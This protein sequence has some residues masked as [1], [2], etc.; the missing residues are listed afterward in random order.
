MCV[1]ARETGDV[2]ICSDLVR[3]SFTKWPWSP[4]YIPSKEVDLL[5]IGGTNGRL[6]LDGIFMGGAYGVGDVA[7][8]SD[9]ETE[10]FT[11]CT[12]STPLIRREALAGAMVVWITVFFQSG[13]TIACA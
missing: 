1:P 13:A 6:F 8:W 12:S 7:S 5:T 2:S 11:P 3:E 4:S 10:S 9:H